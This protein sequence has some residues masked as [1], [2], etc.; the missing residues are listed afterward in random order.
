MPLVSHIIKVF[1]IVSR[2]VDQLLKKLQEANLEEPVDIKQY[3]ARATFQDLWK[4]HCCL[5]ISPSFWCLPAS[6]RVVAPYS[7]DVMTSAAFSIEADS[8]NN[9]DDPL[10]AHLKKITN[11]KLLPLLVSCMFSQV[12]HNMIQFNSQKE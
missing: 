2:C 9:P 10:V 11:F 12:T 6:S 7:L 4:I 5:I 3:D 8:V 1:P